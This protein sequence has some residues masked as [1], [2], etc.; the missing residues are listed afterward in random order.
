MN[1]QKGSNDTNEV[2]RL[3]PISPKKH[4]SNVKKDLPKYGN[5]MF[6]PVQTNDTYHYVCDYKIK[7]SDCRRNGRHTNKWSPCFLLQK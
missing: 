6:Q 4:V 2:C 1:W 5:K 3:F 7:L